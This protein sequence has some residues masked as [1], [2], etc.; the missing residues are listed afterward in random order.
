MHI[1]VS[2]QV[3]YDL[4]AVDAEDVDVRVVAAT[5]PHE[6]LSSSATTSF[7]PWTRV[8]SELG[9]RKMSASYNFEKIQNFYAEFISQFRKI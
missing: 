9:I 4:V 6:H 2:L 3:L 1:P 7:T 5:L 8:M